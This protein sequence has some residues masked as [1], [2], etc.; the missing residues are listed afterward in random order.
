MC[1]FLLN[2]SKNSNLKKTTLAILKILRDNSGDIHL[3]HSFSIIMNGKDTELCSL[4]LKQ[5]GKGAGGGGV[6]PPPRGF[7]KR[8][9][10][11]RR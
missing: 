6:I 2:R 10:L 1:K 4:T 7:L 5:P 9:L 8:Y 11:K 3:D